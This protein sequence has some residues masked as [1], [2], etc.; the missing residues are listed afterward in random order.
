MRCAALHLDSVSG[1]LSPLLPTHLL[2]LGA[3][4]PLV[5]LSSVSACAFFTLKD[6]VTPPL[7]AT[8]YYV[9]GHHCFTIT[10]HLP[11]L[12]RYTVAREEYIH[13][14][15]PPKRLD[16]FQSVRRSFCADK[17]AFRTQ[18][19]QFTSKSQDLLM[20]GRMPTKTCSSLC[21]GRE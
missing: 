9:T 4:G 15:A 2:L 1:M 14:Q 11:R 18:T 7:K 13:E 3:Q 20:F 16:F 21:S 6:G 8:A 17:M 12:T 10:A 5:K 19:N